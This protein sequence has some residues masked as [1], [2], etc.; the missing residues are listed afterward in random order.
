VPKSVL[1]LCRAGSLLGQGIPPLSHYSYVADQPSTKPAFFYPAL[2]YASRHND[3]DYRIHV[4][5]LD[6][7]WEAYHFSISG[8]A[9]TRG[10]YRQADAQH[11][12][13]L[14]TDDFSAAAYVSWLRKMGVR[15]VYLPNAPLGAARTGASTGCAARHRSRWP[16]TAARTPRCWPCCTRP[17]T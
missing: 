2:E 4:V 8:F 11:N 15:D 12:E 9:I 10:W 16:E 13:V 3:P 7:H 1:V 6:T 14:N 5:A 17:Y